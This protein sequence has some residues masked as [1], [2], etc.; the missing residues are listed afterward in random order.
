MTAL[1]PA[2]G[3]EL[4][5]GREASV[6]FALN[7]IRFRVA[8][9][10]PYQPPWGWVWLSGYQLNAAGTAVALREV[11]VRL[12]GLHPVPQPAA[13]VPAQRRPQPLVCQEVS[14]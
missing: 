13:R 14:R 3:Q 11:M 6:Q 10:L 9:V 2:A 8:K 5:L 7:P 12:D 4:L 1:P